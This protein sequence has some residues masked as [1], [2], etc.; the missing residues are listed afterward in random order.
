MRKKASF[1]FV[2]ICCAAISFAQDSSG[3]L[4]SGEDW[5]ILVSAPTGW[6][7]DVQA[8]RPRG[9][10]ALFRKEGERYSAFALNISINSQEKNAGGPVSLAKFMEAD[11]TSLLASDSELVVREL[12]DYSPGME[13]RFALRELDEPGKGYYQTLAY[14]EGGRAFFTIVLSCRSP[15]ERASESGALLKLLDTFVYLSKEK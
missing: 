11:K 7:W 15:E 5:G 13:Y 10:E 4:I 8:Y 2:L 3:G 9:T 12:S 6:V 1:F 14:Y